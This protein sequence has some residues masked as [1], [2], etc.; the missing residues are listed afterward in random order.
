[1]HSQSD[2]V[3]EASVASIGAGPLERFGGDVPPTVAESCLM[4]SG[5]AFGC[6]GSMSM[7]ALVFC[8]HCAST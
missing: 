6:S 5:G 7:C 3:F 4:L 2:G 1:M 8:L